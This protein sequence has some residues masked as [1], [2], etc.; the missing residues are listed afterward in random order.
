MLLALSFF[1]VLSLADGY[2]DPYYLKFTTPTQNHL[3]LGSSKAAQGL[4]PSV[5]NAA[6]GINISN[7]SFDISKS[8]FGPAYLKSIKRKLHPATKTGVFILVV[9]AWSISSRCQNPNDSSSFREKNSCVAQMEHVARNP[10]FRYLT[11]YMFGSYYKLLF[12][13]KVALLHED[14]WLEVTLATDTAA[15]NRRTKSTLQDSENSLAEYK[16]SALRLEY[17]QKTIAFLQNHGTVYLVRL[18]VSPKLMEIENQLISDFNTLLKPI[19][20]QTSGYL[21]LSAKN[22]FYAYT[23]GVHLQ[24]ASGKI[25]SEEIAVWIKTIKLQK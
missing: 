5:F 24:K 23:D 20:A 7:Y 1:A 6:L 8:P 21:D 4:Q 13:S 9:D 17:L 19:A 22:S 18:P 15:V 2:S 12:P 16:F 11:N 3:I 25:V 10:N 14:G